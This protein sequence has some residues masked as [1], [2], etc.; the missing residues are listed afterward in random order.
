MELRH[1]LT[2]V[3]QHCRLIIDSRRCALWN[4]LPSAR[5]YDDFILT[6]HRCCYAALALTNI[7]ARPF[8]SLAHIKIFAFT[9]CFDWTVLYY[10]LKEI[11]RWETDCIDIILVC[12]NILDTNEVKINLLKNLIFYFCKYSINRKS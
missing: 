9:W 7:R 5:S 2:G 11:I 4:Q 12:F 10:I 3:I 8:L 6:M 1:L